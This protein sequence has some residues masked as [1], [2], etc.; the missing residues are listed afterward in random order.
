MQL[1]SGIG[2]HHVCTVVQR[3]GPLRL[4][5]V[6]T[7]CFLSSATTAMALPVAASNSLARP[8]IVYKGAS[9]EIHPA[10]WEPFVMVG[11]KYNS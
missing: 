1:R 8:S 6:V 7:T 11:G 2:D 3:E 5:A 10:Y 9:Q 4:N